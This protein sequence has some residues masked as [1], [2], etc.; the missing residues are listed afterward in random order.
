[1]GIYSDEEDYEAILLD[2]SIYDAHGLRLE[3]GLL[4]R[5]KQ[6]S[7]GPITFILPDVIRQEV[8]SHISRN[9]KAARQAL[10]KA[11]NDASDTDV[12]SFEFSEEIK[13]RALTLQ[14]ID[15]SVSLRLQNF[16][17]VTGALSLE[18]G[19]YVGVSDVLSQYFGNRP[20]FAETG[21]KKSEF[22]DA[23]VLMAVEKWSEVE[24][25][26][27]LAIARDNDWKAFCEQSTAIDYLEDLS[28]GIAHFNDATAPYAALRTISE[29][30]RTEGFLYKEL[31][32][33]LGNVLGEITPEQVADSFLYWEPEGCRAWFNSYRVLDHDFNIVEHDE[34]WVTISVRLEITVTA[35]GDFS[36]SVYD[37]IDRD[38]VSMGGVSVEVEASFESE[39]LITISGDLH[40]EADE[41]AIDEVEVEDVISL[42]D[43]GTIEPDFSGDE[44]D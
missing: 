19:Q 31:E 10:D 42:I 39:V 5:L 15:E 26:K 32:T 20:P 6:F 23:I 2:T 9:T 43:F 1:M 11:I 24:G 28:T 12:V 4:A 38:H 3:R 22:P 7:S 35:E 25:K 33:S 18:C 27:V 36:L 13:G 21:K 17:D 30:L 44:Y 40:G 14:R 16:T 41:L 29:S 37:S 8:F 34:E